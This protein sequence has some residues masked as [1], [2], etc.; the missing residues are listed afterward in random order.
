MHFTGQTVIHVQPWSV[1]KMLCHCDF[2]HFSDGCCSNRGLKKLGSEG[3]DS[4][5]ESLFTQAKGIDAS[6]L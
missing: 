1:A 5:I 2:V 3:G 4:Y 6:L